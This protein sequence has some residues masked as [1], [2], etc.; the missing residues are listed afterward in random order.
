[1][2]KE[3][4]VI[5]E[6][7]VENEEVSAKAEEN[8]EPVVKVEKNEKFG[9]KKAKK[10]KKNAE[11]ESLQEEL[12]AQKESYLRLMAEYENYRKRTASEK[13][14]IY[15]DA[16]AKAVTNLLAVADSMDMALASATNAPEEF[17]KGLELLSQQ[18]TSAFEKM[19]IESFGAIGDVFNPELHN[20]VSKIE[21]EELAENT[22]S[23]VFQKGYKL[24]EKIIRHAMVQVANCD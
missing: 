16:T 17:K 20:A 3:K 21:D 6:E 2:D 14:N 15:A 8:E 11:V 7:I 18:F 9:K 4:E 22:L 19:K 12:K 23:Q 1:M 5:D 24:E 13:L 10:D